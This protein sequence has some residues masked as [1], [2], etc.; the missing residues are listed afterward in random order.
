VSART[1][2]FPTLNKLDY[3]NVLAVFYTCVRINLLIYGLFWYVRSAGYAFVILFKHNLWALKLLR[4]C[5]WRLSFWLTRR[6]DCCIDTTFRKSLLFP[7]IGIQEVYFL[8]PEDGGVSSSET[9]VTVDQTAK[10]CNLELC[11]AQNL[12]LY[13]SFTY[14]VTYNYDASLV[15]LLWSD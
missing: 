7:F 14:T 11:S 12:Y 1:Y 4:H 3:L 13:K 15:A 2:T 5:S 6:V 9:S 10:R 8:N